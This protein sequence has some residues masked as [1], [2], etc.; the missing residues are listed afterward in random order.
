[1]QVVD[2]YIYLLIYFHYVLMDEG[3]KVVFD[4]NA[5]RIID[6]FEIRKSIVS[7]FLEIAF[8]IPKRELNTHG[9][10]FLTDF[11]NNSRWK[12]FRLQKHHYP[13]VGIFI[14]SLRC[15]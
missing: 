6:R 3:Q 14:A 7:K 5:D 2:A 10:P 11:W 8:N 13:K 1:M 15:G 4:S 9:G 12:N